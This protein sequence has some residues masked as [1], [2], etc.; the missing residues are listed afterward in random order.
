VN[1]IRSLLYLLLFVFLIACG[2]AD[3]DHVGVA[4]DRARETGD[5][6]VIDDLTSD[7]RVV[8]KTQIYFGHQSVGSNMLDGF[9]QIADEKR[10]DAIQIVDL[11]REHAASDAFFAHSS[12]G[13]NGDPRSK[14]DEFAEKIREMQKQWPKLIAQ[15]NVVPAL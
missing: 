3:V 5:S 10:V 11:G 7:L 12:V 1:V 8:A 9:R 4:T 6:S 2:R 13:K 14:V 15:E